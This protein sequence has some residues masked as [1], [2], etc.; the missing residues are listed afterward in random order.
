M[1]SDLSTRV[2]VEQVKDQLGSHID[3]TDGGLQNCPR[4]RTATRGTNSLGFGPNQKVFI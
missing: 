3:M 4:P 1:G 2:T